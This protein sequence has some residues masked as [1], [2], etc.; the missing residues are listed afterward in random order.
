MNR[1]NNIHRQQLFHWIGKH[2]DDKAG[3]EPLTDDLRQDY[4]ACLES[5]LE[6]GLW[7]KIPRQPDCLGDG[8]QIKVRR[9]IVCFTEWSLGQSLP[10]TSRYGRLALGFPKRF[11]L[12]HGGQPVIYVR[13]QVKKDP[14]T[15]ALKQLALFFANAKGNSPAESKTLRSLGDQFDYLAHFAKRIRREASL[16]KPA[17]TPKRKRAAAPVVAKEP[18][19]FDRRYGETL[20][21]LEEREW[22]IVHDAA[23]QDFFVK[24]PY[25]RQDQHLPQYYLEFEPGRE[26]F[27]VVLPDNRTV[28]MAMSKKRLAQKLFPSEAP[29]VTILSLQDIGT[30]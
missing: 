26:L 16:P 5:A 20:H 1:Y 8:S 22:R 19:P 11:V 17:P 27:T 18:N 21:Y 6:D 15:A 4:V 13:D 7:L 3:G 2:I 14:Y 23:L 29:H 10:H 12:A 30:F 25:S 24:G 9:P 28:N